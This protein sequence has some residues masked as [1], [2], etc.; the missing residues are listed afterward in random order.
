MKPENEKKYIYP[1]VR[2]VPDKDEKGVFLIDER[3]KEWKSGTLEVALYETRKNGDSYFLAGFNEKMS[4]AKYKVTRE[5]IDHLTVDELRDYFPALK[6]Q[7]LEETE[8]KTSDEDADLR[9]EI[10]ELKKALDKANEKA[11][12]T[13]STETTGKTDG[14]SGAKA[15]KQKGKSASKTDA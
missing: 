5:E 4:F 8:P 3:T 2:F 13:A 14:E 7:K 9:K 11:S 6:V 1:A 12:T 10:E 15:T